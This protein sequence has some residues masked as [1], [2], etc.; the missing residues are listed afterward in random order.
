[1]DE[2][3]GEDE[4]PQ[5]PEATPLP[6]PP[7]VIDLMNQA[8]AAQGNAFSQAMPRLGQYAQTL[9]DISGAQ[10]P[11]LLQQFL[12]NQRVGGPALVGMAV[13]AVKQA[14]PS[15]F[16]LRESLMSRVA[17][18]LAAGGGLTADEERRNREDLRQAQANR[19]FGTG[20][21][22]AYEES[23]FMNS[24]RFAREQARIA[25]AMQALSGRTPMDYFSQVNQAGRIAPFQ[26]QD[27]SG[28]AGNLIPSTTSLMGV[29]QNAYG[30]QVNNINA[31]NQMRQH[32]FEFGIQNARNPM[33]EDIGFLINAGQGLA[34]IAGS[35]F[36]SAMGNP[37]AGM[38]LAGNLG[39]FSGMGSSP[40]PVSSFDPN[41]W[42][43]YFR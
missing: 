40:N 9:T 37:M 41:A 20:L 2:I 1:M 12:Q 36:G 23:A 3:F 38:S 27:V 19:G 26:S 16:S 29:G 33:K 30:Q 6:P 42:G 8:S 5:S 4:V 31:E 32:Q 10:S 13:D 17:N 34:G 22:D 7:S 15:G 11:Q 39:S 14:D 18:N 21:A 35:A 43:G 24:Q 28:M 25:N